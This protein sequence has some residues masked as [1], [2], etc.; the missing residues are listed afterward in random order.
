MKAKHTF[1]LISC[2]WI[3]VTTKD[4]KTEYVG[5]KTLFE[6]AEDYIEITSESELITWCI[7]TLIL[8]IVFTSCNRDEYLYEMNT[9]TFDYKKV[10]P[11]IL[12]YLADNADKFDLYDKTHPFL[13]LPK[14]NENFMALPKKERLVKV[15]SIEELNIFDMSDNKQNKWSSDKPSQNDIDAWIA[16]HFI[17]FRLIHCNVNKQ[18]PDIKEHFFSCLRDETSTYIPCFYKGYSLAETIKLNF[19]NTWYDPDDED[20]RV[21]ITPDWDCDYSDF[22][23]E[24]AF[25]EIEENKKQS[26]EN[27]E[28]SIKQITT[29][30]PDYDIARFYTYSNVLINIDRDNLSFMVI[31]NHPLD[32]SIFNYKDINLL[33]NDKPV[34]HVIKESWTVYSLK[35]MESLCLNRNFLNSIKGII[36]LPKIVMPQHRTSIKSVR[37]RKLMCES[38]LQYLNKRTKGAN[39]KEIDSFI[40]TISDFKFSEHISIYGEWMRK[41]IYAEKLADR[42]KKVRE[43]CEENINFLVELFSQDVE[44]DINNYFYNSIIGDRETIKD[45][46]RISDNN[47]SKEDFYKQCIRK[48]YNRCEKEKLNLIE[49]S[50]NPYKLFDI[51]PVYNTQ[52]KKNHFCFV[53][54]K[55]MR[56]NEEKYSTKDAFKLFKLRSN[57][58][59]NGG[60]TD[61]LLMKK[62]RKR[63]NL[64]IID[65]SNE[66]I[67]MN[68]AHNKECIDNG[69]RDALYLWAIYQRNIWRRNPSRFA[70]T[71]DNNKNNTPR[72][73]GDDPKSEEYFAYKH[74]LGHLLHLEYVMDNKEKKNDEKNENLIKKYEKKAKNFE[75]LL[76][77]FAHL[78]D[79][80]ECNISINFG[81]L[82]CLF[83]EYYENSDINKLCQDIR[84]GFEIS[85]L[86]YHNKK[87]KQL[88]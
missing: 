25:N 71:F 59:L 29:Q 24:K 14:N 13:Q 51:T 80:T 52:E 84:D 39:S 22:D 40:K 27:K 73:C 55:S 70:D 1:S 32:K 11:F 78:L 79:K 19:I 86:K 58:A 26:K 47:I 48:I 6:N 87:Q 85:C 17:T 49:K 83:A 23:K 60:F 16:R 61:T 12:A 10:K 56:K 45:N 41:F 33:M 63:E 76:S 38:I 18:F 30:I 8:A 88:A 34:M 50:K 69:V 21:R 36:T 31:Y 65:F 35:W 53:K 66:N 43:K 68:Y 20:T 37:H 28:K 67:S 3:W 54:E 9:N 64:S 62:Y 7:H 77:F 72:V 74:S 2:P 75:N 5:L 46:H 81:K 44:N 4:F 42:D 82:A 57:A 15:H